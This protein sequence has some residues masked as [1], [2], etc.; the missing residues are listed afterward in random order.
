[1]NDET[2]LSLI[3]ESNLIPAQLKEVVVKD[4]CKITASLITKARITSLYNLRRD[5]N[6]ADERYRE[7]NL[8]I[9]RMLGMLRAYPKE[10][11]L[12]IN[13]LCSDR[14]LVVFASET[15]DQIF[16]I[17]DY[18]GLGNTISYLKSLLQ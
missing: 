9:D 1:M 8:Q 17:F 3:K 6:N 14:Y 11:L 15:L 7:I 2:L 18:T 10:V 5:G 4:G 12:V 13:V 16:E